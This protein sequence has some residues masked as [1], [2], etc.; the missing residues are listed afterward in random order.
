VDGVPP[1][2]ARGPGTADAV[3]L[4]LAAI[5]GAGVFGVWGPAAAVAGTW[6]PL[7]VV[8][9]G[10]AALCAA[11]AGADVALTHPGGC[12]VG[13]TALLS[14]A[15][16]RLAGV[17][18]LLG[19]AAAAATAAAVFGS[20]VLPTWPVL[21]GVGLV[22]VVTGL[23]V[24]GAAWTARSAWALVGGLGIVLLAVVL[25][26]VAA[27]GGGRH[28]IPAAAQ[29]LVPVGP[30]SA[31]A[32]GVLTAAGL[33][34]FAFAGFARL[35]PL[36]AQLRNPRR[37]LRLVVGLTLGV[38]LVVNL[39]VAVALLAGL[40]TEPLTSAPAP[41][42]ALVDAGGAPALGVLVRIGAAV[43]CGSALLAVLAGWSRT[44]AAMAERGELPRALAALGP[45]GTPWRAD[46]VGGV[47]AIVVVV[48]A[49]PVGALAVAAC[50]L[51]VH[52]ALVGL[53][54]V[55]LPAPRRSWPAWVFAAGAV[56]CV[57]LA[58]L[59]PLRAL[60]VTVLVLA[61]LWGLATMHARRVGAG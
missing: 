61:V 11:A 26:G 52:Y 54:A 36:G 17:A 39:A 20:Y 4:G 60:A 10:V 5:L 9:A 58:L 50:A 3:V 28:Q 44:A 14:P 56:L 6:L 15:G 32:P 8:V 40:G 2:V 18:Y 55:L 12:A 25:V 42:A 23:T 24:A 19:R 43:A 45:G 33:V 1:S 22:V 49:G 31:G 27:A 51:L 38:V 34:F 16:A 47:A 41:L 46:V 37:T 53:A 29:L 7:A 13:G 35:F 30:A 59:L 21:T 57:L 48:L